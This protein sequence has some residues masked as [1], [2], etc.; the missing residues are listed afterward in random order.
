MDAC[1]AAR[2]AQ[3][4]ETLIPGPS[5]PKAFFI[6]AADRTLKI[7]APRFRLRIEIQRAKRD[8][9]FSRP[10]LIVLSNAN[11]PDAVPCTVLRRADVAG[12][13]GRYKL[14]V[15]H[16]TGRIDFEKVSTALIVV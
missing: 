11:C 2:I 3:T 6:L 9:D 4:E 14:R 1:D 5:R 15:A 8:V 10:A 7:G 13:L 16:R 12:P